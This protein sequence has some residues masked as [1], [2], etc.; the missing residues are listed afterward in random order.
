M[1]TETIA[2]IATPLGQGGL[3]VIRISGSRAFEVADV[4]FKRAGSKHRSLTELPSHTVH[5]GHIV[6]QG[7]VIDEVLTTILRAPRTYTRE[8]TV[9]ISCHGGMTATAAVLE[10]SL[11]AGARLAEPGEFTRRAFINGRIDLTQ[12]EAV[13]DLISARTQLALKAAEEQLAGRL[14][15][16][17]EEI[18]SSL[19]RV[20][21]HVEAHIDFPDEDIEPDTQQSLLTSL[22]STHGGMIGLMATADEGQLLRHGV[23]AV[24]LGRPNSGKSSLL[25]QLLGRARAIVSPIAGTTRD[26]IE[27]TADVLGLPI[28]FIDTAGVRE[29]ADLLEQEGIRRSLESARQAELILYVLDQSQAVDTQDLE[30]LREF[31]GRT[32][33]TVL[34]KADLPRHA[35]VVS[36][37][38]NGTATNAQTGEGVEE[39]K[40]EIHRRFWRGDVQATAENVMI[41]ARHKEALRRASTAVEATMRALEENVGLE[42]VA[43]E[44]RICVHAVGEIVGHTTTEDLLDSIFSQFCIGK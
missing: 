36:E 1:L 4:I 40:R 23:R 7:E 44:L 21:A 37:I 10:A 29:S 5:Y 18:R 24:I 38:D 43:M 6:R 22:A 31:Q 3:A 34:N 26:T 16:K 8:H 9:E 11:A 27:E 42:L 2:A 41:N 14:A 19:M 12:A 39:L 30:L 17:V 15:K 20:L 28:R 32:L 33:I 25:N 13:A 35:T